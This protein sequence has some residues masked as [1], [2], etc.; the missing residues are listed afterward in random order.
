MEIIIKILP[1]FGI[2]GLL[3]VFVKNNWVTKQEVGNEKMV[4]I[5]KNISSGAMSFLKA[6]YKIL[7]IFVICLAILLYVKGENEEA[8]TGICGLSEGPALN[9]QVTPLSTCCSSSCEAF[10]DSPPLLPRQLGRTPE[11]LLP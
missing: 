9:L 6:E 10:W 4:T 11:L 3:F 2:L 1:V 5:A 7:S 8:C